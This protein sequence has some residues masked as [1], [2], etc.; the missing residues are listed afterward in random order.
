DQAGIER[1]LVA[2]PGV[3]AGAVVTAGVPRRARC[4]HHAAMRIGLE[5]GAD[6]L[7]AV[8]E[9]RLFRAL[10][11]EEDGVDGVE[12][13]DRLHGH[14]ARIAGADTDHEDLS[15]AGR[16]LRG[17]QAGGCYKL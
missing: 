10:V 1:R 8:Q 15:H 17:P 13:L 7:A 14:V 9:V 3:D 5:P 6:L 4:R 16:L 12:R 2:M 11:E